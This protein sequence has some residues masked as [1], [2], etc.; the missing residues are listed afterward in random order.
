MTWFFTDNLLCGP[1]S[2]V[3]FSK[4]EC[5]DL[6]QV[7]QNLSKPQNSSNSPGKTVFL[8]WLLREVCSFRDAEMYGQHTLKVFQHHRDRRNASRALNNMDDTKHRKPR[9]FLMTGLG[10]IINVFF[11]SIPW[12]YHTHVSQASEYHGRLE[13][14]KRNWNAYIDRLVKEYSHFLLISTVLLSAAVGFLAIEELSQPVLIASTISA[15]AALGSIIVGVFS[16]WR[17]QTNN[18]N[19]RNASSTQFTYMNNIRH[20]AFGFYGHAMLLLLLLPPYHE[21]PI[22]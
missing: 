11:F 3:P 14:V 12:T 9:G 22:L 15:L 17:H 8:A 10:V 5:A 16:M 19:D 6:S 18:I 13:N 1:R 20:N 21:T 2:V 4:E 7:V